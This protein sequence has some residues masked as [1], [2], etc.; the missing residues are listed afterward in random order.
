M[1]RPLPELAPKRVSADRAFFP[2]AALFAASAIPLWLALRGTVLAPLWHGHEM[3]FGYALAVVAGFLVTRASRRT[4]A[5]LVI[6]WVAARVATAADNGLGAAVAGL[7]FPLVLL[8]TAA[9]PIWRG[10]KRGENRIAP[11]LLAALCVLDALWW[12]GAVRHDPAP[13][14]RA[15]LATIDLLAL[16]M[17]VIGGRALPAAVGGYLERKGI[18]RQDMIRSGGYELPL[19]ALMAVA[20]VADLA[21][22][23]ALAG[24]FNVAAALLTV[25]RA[26]AWQLRYVVRHVQ[27]WSLAVAYLWLI[28][29]LLL[30]GLG[31]F[32]A[33]WPPSQALHAYTV[34]ALGALTI[35]MMA[36]TAIIRARRP[37]APFGDIGA[38]V[39]LVSLSAILRLAATPALP[40]REAVLWLS[41]GAWMLAFAILLARLLRVAQSG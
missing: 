10:A 20:C 19:A 21:G 25:W 23:I 27:L 31:P 13:Q 9:P 8:A 29:A 37:L 36:R 34:G 28:P 14:S 30:K 6:T 4:I 22:V 26:R 3:L 16:L 7:S 15:L 41:A 40:W 1:P 35:V 2:L 39:L 33:G 32:V 5:L 12:A 38:A 17:L 18:P 11:V 24:A